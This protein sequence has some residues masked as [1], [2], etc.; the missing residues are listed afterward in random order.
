MRGL[1]GMLKCCCGQAYNVMSAVVKQ[2]VE[3]GVTVSSRVLEVR[4]TDVSWF[5]R[6]WAGQQ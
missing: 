1:L 6:V 4:D 3:P 2:R 5:P